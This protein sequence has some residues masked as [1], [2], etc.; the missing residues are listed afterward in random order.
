[1]SLIEEILSVENMN[2]AIKKV[3]SNKGASGIDKMKD[4]DRLPEYAVLDDII[5]M[6]LEQNISVEEIYKKYDK[7]IVDEVVRKI[8]RMQFKRHQGCLGVRLTER[9]FCNGVNLPVVQR[10]Y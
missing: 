1:M 5:E 7:S 3:K 2:E 4:Q 8:Y 6:Y 9:S 10:Y